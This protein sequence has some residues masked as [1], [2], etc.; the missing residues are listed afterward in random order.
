M[1]RMLAVG[2]LGAALTPGALAFT[3]SGLVLRGS[4]SVRTCRVPTGA[5]Q[6]CRVPAGASLRMTD[7]T[8]EKAWSPAGMTVEDFYERSIG[9]WRAWLVRASVIFEHA[10]VCLLVCIFK[11]MPLSLSEQSF[12]LM[13]SATIASSG[14]GHQVREI[15]KS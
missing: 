14:L 12:W 10:S 8:A 7:A 6:T 5:V 3:S 15:C 9:C 4:T 13:L 2:L 1:L 11:D